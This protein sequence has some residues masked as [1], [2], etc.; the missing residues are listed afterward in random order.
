MPLPEYYA[1]LRLYGKRQTPA[2]R[3]AVKS[4]TGREFWRESGGV[5]GRRFAVRRVRLNNDVNADLDLL[6]GQVSTAVFV[7]MPDYDIRWYS[8]EAENFY[9]TVSDREK[10]QRREAITKLA[11]EKLN[12]DLK[13]QQTDE[14]KKRLKTIAK[15]LAQLA[16]SGQGF[17]NTAYNCLGTKA[18]GI[19][20]GLAVG[21]VPLQLQFVNSI[22]PDRALS[23]RIKRM[24]P[25]PDQGKHE[26]ALHFGDDRKHYALVMGRDKSVEWR[27]YKPMAAGARDLLEDELNNALDAGRLTAADEKQ[28]GKWEREAKA[29][30]EAGADS[31]AAKLQLADLKIKEDKLREDKKHAGDAA[32]ADVERLEKILFYDK[33]AVTLPEYVK[34]TYGLSFDITVEWLRRGG[35][36]ITIGDNEPFVWFDKTQRANVNFVSMINRRSKLT[37]KSTGGEFSLALGAP[38]YAPHSI[39][40]GAP[41]TVPSSAGVADFDFIAVSSPTALALNPANSTWETPPDPTLPDARAT[42]KVE[43]T[44]PAR[45]LAASGATLPTTYQVRLDLY[46]NGNYATE[47]YGLDFLITPR[48]VEFSGLIYDSENDVDASG[49]RH[50]R[51]CQISASGGNSVVAVCNVRDGLVN[52]AAES[53]LPPLDLGKRVA[54]VS[55]IDAVTGDEHYIV[56]H[57]RVETDEYRVLESL[58]WSTGTTTPPPGAN[59]PLMPMPTAGSDREIT[60][61]GLEQ[62]LNV[63]CDAA[64]AVDGQ[65][66][67]DAL[68]LYAKLGGLAPDEYAGI[69]AGDIDG[70]SAIALPPAGTQPRVRPDDNTLIWAFMQ[71]L[72]ADHAPGWEV[73]A[74]NE[75]LRLQE[76]IERDRPDLNYSE[77][78]PIDSTLR[79]LR[80]LT[81]RVDFADFANRVIGIGA[82]DPLSRVRIVVED[83]NPL[84]FDPQFEGKSLTYCGEQLAVAIGPNETWQDETAVL[85]AVREELKK[86]GRPPI[87][88]VAVVPY[89]PDVKGGDLPYIK[90]RQWVVDKMER[91]EI[92]SAPATDQRM[93]LILR[94]AKDILT[95]TPANPIN[96]D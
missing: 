39:V 33:A 1:R 40:S 23:F 96:P 67:G 66:V 12:L 62:F 59:P 46:S 69:T 49:A 48:R 19:Y 65:F 58:N 51:D 63:F 54:D 78:A 3:P 42:A 92:N 80:P 88:A 71:R 61:V 9:Q 60:V 41:F 44:R 94:L 17:F 8:V 25:P 28:L 86:R 27:H 21:N 53:N 14:D 35:A 2:I 55:L 4:L 70:L 31:N 18:R 45:Q 10:T 93:T 64:V 7:L 13:Q 43:T 24:E 68:R 38:N 76:V 16:D 26:L 36:L 34:T 84:S 57:G 52:G 81:L 91:G 29:V 82:E 6:P 74:D 75:G 83:A 89:R 79:L 90:G 37:I 47:I 56:W 77:D 73:I 32:R 15:Q 72:V 85:L 22:K 30:K 95:A 20:Y 5:E 11:V 87:Y 50:L